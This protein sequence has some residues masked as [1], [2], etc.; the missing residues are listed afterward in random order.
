MQ[1][2]TTGYAMDELTEAAALAVRAPS[3]HNS[4]PWRFALNDGAI[5]VRLDPARLPDIPAR[6]WAGRVS[7]GAAV[8]NLRLALAALGRPPAVVVRPV[9]RDVIAELVPDVPR[10]PSGA[11]RALHAAIPRRC[12]NR[13]PFRTEAVPADLRARLVAA[14]RAEGGWLDL[15]I[16]ASAVNALAEV[17]NAA[18][19]VLRRDPA[20]AA[21]LARWRRD[22][23]SAEDGVAERA[24]GYSPEPQDLLPMRAFGARTRPPGRDYEPEPLVAVLGTATDREADQVTAGQALERVLLTATDAGLAV[25]MF[26]Q[27]IEVP[28]ARARLRAALG[29]QGVPQLVLRIG[30][31]QPGR[32]TPRRPVAAVIDP[33]V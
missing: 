7:C 19:R 10:P 13:M 5:E 17:V 21:E 16:G 11:E 15:I 6:A 26:S 29:R 9:D 18:N 31:G 20:Y 25:S 8:F 3:M 32:P 4:Q 22:G 12:S 24:A 2:T 14:A 1:A 28:T 33:D 27:A 23:G 30:Y